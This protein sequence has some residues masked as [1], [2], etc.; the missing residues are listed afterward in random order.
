MDKNIKNL[1]NILNITNVDDFNNVV[2]VKVNYDK[3]TNLGTFYLKIESNIYKVLFILEQH[4]IKMDLKFSFK[5]IPPN[6][7]LKLFINTMIY[8]ILEA[9]D[10]FNKSKMDQEDIMCNIEKRT[11][12]INVKNQINFQPVNK[13]K[14]KIL[15]A[16][17]SCS[18]KYDLIINN[19]TE[20][21][22]LLTQ[23][24]VN[25]EIQNKA[26]HFTNQPVKK[27]DQYKEVSISNFH[28]DKNSPPKEK[29][30]IVGHIFDKK[31][32][33]INLKVDGSKAYIIQYSITDRNNSVFVTLFTRNHEYAKKI[34]SYEIGSWATFFGIKTF[35]KFHNEYVLG[36]KYIEHFDYVEKINKF[37]NPDTLP[38]KRV[39]LNAHT[40]MSIMDGISSASELIKCAALEYKHNS[41]AITDINSCQAFPEIMKTYDYISKM[42]DDF[43]IIYGVELTLI[44]DEP[45]FICNLNNKKIDDVIISFDTETTGLYPFT[46]DI[47][48][49]GA[50]KVINGVESTKPSDRI[51]FFIKTD[52]IISSKITKITNITNKMV[53]EEGIKPK[54]AIE[55]I[56]KFVGNY[57]L[58]A[59]NA[60]FDWSF[61]K[62]L[63]SKHN[64]P[65]LKNTIL[66]TMYLARMLK[67]NSRSYSLDYLASMHAKIKNYDSSVAHRADYDSKILGKVYEWLLKICK[68]EYPNIITFSDLY[69]LFKEKL[70]NKDEIRKYQYGSNI[71][72]LAKNQ[73]GLKSL[74]RLLSF[75]NTAN[76]FG[77]PTIFKEQIEKYRE[78]LVVISPGINGEVFKSVLTKTDEELVPIVK[79]YDAIAIHPVANMSHLLDEKKIETIK[80][81]QSI[82]CKSIEIAKENNVIS[83]ASC[84][85]YY[86]FSNQKIGRDILINSKRVFNKVHPL[87]NYKNPTRANPDQ[88]YRNTEEMMSAFDFLHKIEAIELVITNTLLIDSLCENKIIPILKG[89]H[90][91]KIDNSKKLLKDLVYKNMRSIYGEKLPPFIKNRLESE[92]DAIIKNGYEVIY[93]ISKLLVS[94]SLADGYLVGSRGSVG[95]S[96]VAF[97]I[98]ISEVNPLIPHYLCVNCQ[99]VKE[100]TD[101]N[102]TSGFDLP[103]KKCPK[104]EN[105]LLSDGQSIPFETFLGLP[106]KHKI[107]DIDLNFSADY[108]WRAHNCIKEI[109]GESHVF[110]AGTISTVKERTAY[111]YVK[112]FIETHNK[113]YTQAEISRLCKLC[114]GVKRT[115]GQHPG[116]II[117]VP[118]KLS[119]LDFTP[120]AYPADDISS[121]WY[122]SHFSF[123]AIH[124]NLLKID[125][126]GHLDP[127]ALK[128]LF[129]LTKIKVKDIPNNDP[130]VLSLFNN[131]KELNIKNHSNFKNNS[132]THG[133]PEFGTE[134][135]IEMLGKAKPTSFADLIRISG[136]SHG[137]DVWRNNSEDLLLKHNK[138]L[139]NLITCRDD[140]MNYLM[141]KGIDSKIAFEIMES[142]RKGN[143]IS[144]EYIQL[145]SNNGVDGWYI[146]SCIKI[147]Y[148][149]PK[150]H[151]TAY[152]IMAWRI[153]WFK[154]YYPLAY[155]AVFFS[156]RCNQFSYPLQLKDVD[157]LINDYNRLMKL[158]KRTTK[159]SSLL[160]TLNLSIEMK[161]RGYDFEKI[162][163]EKSLASDFVINEKN[164]T[165]II[166]F[167]S[168]DG[169][170][171]EVAESIIKE[172]VISPF[173]SLEDLKK[174]TK[175]NKNNIKF[176]NKY[177]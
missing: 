88:Y 129:H 16:L 158:K 151:A 22:I 144:T 79:F 36:I 156:I 44:N 115:T 75:A 70:K 112:A 116:G 117:V 2:V 17:K 134:F 46:C 138:Q 118:K 34:G 85:P 9:E 6:N 141:S 47:I 10:G 125:I 114:S 176:F 99:Y 89:L 167:N 21:N 132:G 18:L 24:L 32:H 74:Y 160:L 11:I 148:L 28:I 39:E 73:Q 57:P 82:I 108:Q 171:N 93:W 92:L 54:K 121:S 60:S 106:D 51:Q 149:F 31:F 119:I 40:K 53:K 177:F 150:A 38:V 19:D 107:P 161:L 131:T 153:A 64:V 124:D 42:R 35:N 147:K 66:D 105:R 152:V 23:E 127:L 159:E 172:R 76:Y 83:Y 166:P 110:R 157:T 162:D 100:T 12:K 168:I 103:I 139:K 143:G 109:F 123:E 122:T 98:N 61:L 170:G 15:F 163:I 154:I 48:E 55:K 13:T 91:P 5:V 97:A 142:V 126:L 45:F 26:I 87:Y 68:E 94:K 145:L 71:T 56:I 95:S 1:L 86:T 27:T 4:A 90:K 3:L 72:L 84:N 101:P 81:A 130:R 136:L 169:L 29:Y 104:C 58:I 133:I 33:P 52:K 96:L 77:K 137:T 155:Y 20:N 120:Y 14:F 49:F 63:F 67:P 174:R 78:N 102:I 164:K 30:K 62:K 41:I 175:L 135:V 128:K 146:N 37:S 8:E 111:G 69:G 80:Q 65:M 173:I 7:D 165:L 59:H 113:N 50:V 25:K 43:K 140:I